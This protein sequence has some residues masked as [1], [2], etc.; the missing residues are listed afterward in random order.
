MNLIK[1]WKLLHQIEDLNEEFNEGHVQRNLSMLV[2]H[3]QIY[4]L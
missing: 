2:V 4:Q 3:F 1:I